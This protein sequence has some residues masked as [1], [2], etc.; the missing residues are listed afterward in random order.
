V[1]ALSGVW[2]ARWSWLRL[3]GA[4]GGGLVLLPVV[5][6][7]AY[8]SSAVGSAASPPT[9]VVNRYSIS[10]AIKASQQGTDPNGTAG[11]TVWSDT[12][13]WLGSWTNVPLEVF[14]SAGK[15][16][17]AGGNAKNGTI[18]ASESFIYNDPPGVYEP[19]NCMGNV[20]TQTYTDGSVAV[21]SVSAETFSA[22]TPSATVFTDAVRSEVDSRCSTIALS[23]YE[24]PVTFPFT[25]PDG[26]TFSDLDAQLLDLMLSAPTPTAATPALNVL[27]ISA[28]VAGRSFDLESGQHTQSTS[29]RSV[30]EAVSIEFKFLGKGKQPTSGSG[31]GAAVCRVPLLK[32]R[33]LSSARSLLKAAG[34]RLGK[35]TTTSVRPRAALRVTAQSRKAGAIRPHG[36]PIGV[37]L[38]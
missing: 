6:S 5:G 23:V 1:E 4:V 30:T 2:V 11:N 19:I 17:N 20:P 33:T 3:L 10:F 27:P 22:G 14:Y 16:F 37:T 13:Q 32:G 28:I 25:A 29:D 24:P 9:I 38:G 15:P 26:V 12:Q 21:S 31:G 18:Q 7:A 35:V 36:S 8:A 34:C